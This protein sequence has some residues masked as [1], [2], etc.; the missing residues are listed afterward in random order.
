[1]IIKTKSINRQYHWFLWFIIIVASFLRFWN[2]FEIPFTH[3]EFSALFRTRFA[4][5]SELV[6][7]GIMPD[8]H[9]AGVQLFL[10]FWVKLV[11]FSEPWV[12]LPFMLMG[13][14]SLFL[15][16]KIG[17]EWFSKQVALWA[18]ASLA[19]MQYFINV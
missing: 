12:K 16:W 18:T 6:E 5:F 2:F 13:L 17:T 7:K 3:D 11:G 8:G 9:S 1:M 4:S 10:Y 15:I 14:A 19:F